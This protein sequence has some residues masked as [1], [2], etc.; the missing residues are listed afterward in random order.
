M[1]TGSIDIVEIQPGVL[2]LRLPSLQLPAD[3]VNAWLLR[4]CL[5]TP[6]GPRPGWTVLDTGPDTPQ[7]RALWQT[8]FADHLDGLPVLRVCVTRAK[9]DNAGLARWLCEWW[10]AGAGGGDCPLW[11]SAG[12]F[13]AAHRMVHSASLGVELAVQFAASHGVQDAAALDGIRAYAVRQADGAPR[14]P[15][16]FR[17][18]VAGRG[19]ALG[20]ADH[21][22]MLTCLVGWGHA[23]E[24]MSLYC[25]QSQTLYAGDMLC[26]DRPTIVRVAPEEPDADAVHLLLDSLETL[27]DLPPGVTLYSAR[28]RGLVSLSQRV[29]DMQ[30]YWAAQLA[31]VLTGCSSGPVT[32]HALTQRWTPVPATTAALAEPQPLVPALNKTIACLNALW[33]AR[34]LERES[35]NGVW[36]FHS[37]S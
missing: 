31:E 25:H 32:A 26:P 21:Q 34:L 35:R 6:H 27:R 5:D 13:Y 15:N 22:R 1:F 3:P 9:A 11:I 16:R 7:A 2:C 29:S 4:D 36:W 10:S 30:A 19:L 20:Q 28:G 33:H 8:V 12:E 14:L 24:G 37:R 23:V 18:L 17:R